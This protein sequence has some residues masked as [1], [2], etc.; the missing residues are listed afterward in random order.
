MKDNFRPYKH[1]SNSDEK[2]KKFTFLKI[3]KF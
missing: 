2:K 3:V 1:F